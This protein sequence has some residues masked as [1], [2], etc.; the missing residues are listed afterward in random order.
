LAPARDQS[1]LYAGGVVCFKKTPVDT[2]ACRGDRS[3]AAT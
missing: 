2:T 1:A 3:E